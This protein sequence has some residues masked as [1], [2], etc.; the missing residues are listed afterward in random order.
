MQS[1]DLTETYAY[2]ISEDLVC[3]EEEI[4]YSNI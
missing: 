4:K 2:W 1:I 3:G